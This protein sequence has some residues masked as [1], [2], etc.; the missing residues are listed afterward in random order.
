MGQDRGRCERCFKRHRSRLTTS[1]VE[2]KNLPLCARLTLRSPGDTIRL[3]RFS[4]GSSNR[5]NERRFFSNL[6]PRVIACLFAILM[7]RLIG[8]VTSFNGRVA[9]MYRRI[10][11]FRYYNNVVSR[12]RWNSLNLQIENKPTW[13]K[14]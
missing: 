8:R 10:A 12:M 9:A 6:F 13:N 3:P 1:D 7:R 2:M 4:V 5:S 14:T 11:E